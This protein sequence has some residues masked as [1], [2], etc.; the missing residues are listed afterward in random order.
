MAAGSS[1]GCLGRECWDAAS[2]G[3]VPLAAGSWLDRLGN[4]SAEGGRTGS[5]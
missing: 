1:T 3:E 2:P 5:A 4:S